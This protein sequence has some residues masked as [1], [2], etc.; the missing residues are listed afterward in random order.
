MSFDKDTTSKKGTT[1]AGIVNQDDETLSLGWTPQ[2]IKAIIREN[3]DGIYYIKRINSAGI[4][5]LNQG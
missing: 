4:E 1:S 5:V 2:F 3:E